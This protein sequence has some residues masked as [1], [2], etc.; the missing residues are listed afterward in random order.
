MCIK[1]LVSI[2]LVL[3]PPSQL[4]P[5]PFPD[6]GLP[7]PLLWAGEAA[8]ES[9]EDSARSLHVVVCV[10]HQLMLEVIVSYQQYHIEQGNPPGTPPAPRPSCSSRCTRPRSPRRR[11]PTPAQPAGLSCPI[12]CETTKFMAFLLHK[13]SISFYQRC[14]N[15]IV[16][17][18][19]MFHSKAASNPLKGG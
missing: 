6:H 15:F 4:P 5:T 9:I 14:Y 10:P 7:R 18:A 1:T 12:L 8:V 2:N 13:T 16:S 3:T 19:N 11:R 17:L